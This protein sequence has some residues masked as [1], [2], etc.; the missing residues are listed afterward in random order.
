MESKKSKVIAL[1]KKEFKDKIFDYSFSKDWSYKGGMPAV[2]D[3]YADWCGPCKVVAPILNQLSVEY[4]GKVK[5]YKVNTEKD[6]QVAK[7]FGIT[8]IPTL[9]FIEPEKNPVM[10]RGAQ[11]IQSLR[12]N[13]D[14][15]LPKEK[16]GF[17]KN[18][19]SFNRK[20]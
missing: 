9:L 20:G 18:L 3:F 4:E 13:I 19:L 15:I 14:N 11:S 6:P 12:K 2:I 7:V 16:G 5:F 10:V 8:S 1:N 17:L